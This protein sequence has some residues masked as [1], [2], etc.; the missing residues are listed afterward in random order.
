MNTVEIDTDKLVPPYTFNTLGELPATYTGTLEFLKL[1]RVSGWD[2]VTVGKIA[3]E[4][5]TKNLTAVYSNDFEDGVIYL[6]PKQ[7]VRYM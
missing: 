7:Q 3:H 1:F 6:N 5:G 4:Q 2:V